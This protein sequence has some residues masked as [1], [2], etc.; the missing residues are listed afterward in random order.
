[1]KNKIQNFALMGASGYIAP[2]HMKAIK[3]TGNNLAVAYDINDSVGQM[4]AFFPNASFFTEFERF[5]RHIDKIRRSQQDSVDYI[6]ICSPNYLHDSHIRFSLK[7]AANVICE[8]PL[9]LNTRNLVGLREIEDDC[10]K[11]INTILQL[12]LHPSIVSLKE[13]IK[14]NKVDTAHKH[15]VILTYIASRGLW[16]KYSW[17]GDIEKS[18]GVATNIGVHFFDMLHYLFGDVEETQTHFLNNNCASGYLEYSGARVLWFLSIDSDDLPRESKEDGQT[19]FRSIKIDG[20]EIEFS[21]GFTELHTKSYESILEG[22]GFG[23]DDVESSIQT[24][25]D[26][27]NSEQKLQTDCHPYLKRKNNK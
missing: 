9:V 21:D 19:T 20:K 15:D 3:D 27:R 18:G 25:E 8:K 13:K 23:I 5:D 22:D 12:R 4:D 16:Y 10:N 26:I 7:S 2:R 1:M 11:K 17:K 24:V 6:S 14:E